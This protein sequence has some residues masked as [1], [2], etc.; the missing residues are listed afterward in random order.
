MPSRSGR[1]RSSKSRLFPWFRSSGKRGESDDARSRALEESRAGAE[2]GTWTRRGTGYDGPAAGGSTGTDTGIGTSRG[3]GS[4]YFPTHSTLVPTTSFSRDFTSI[5]TSATAIPA[6]DTDG[7]PSGFVLSWTGKGSILRGQWPWKNYAEISVLPN[8]FKQSVDVDSS[9]QSSRST[10]SRAKSR[11][12]ELESIYSSELPKQLFG[13]SAAYDESSAVRQRHYED[14][15][16]SM[17]RDYLS[18]GK[19]YSDFAHVPYSG[20]SYRSFKRDEKALKLTGASSLDASPAGSVPG[21][22]VPPRVQPGWE[23]TACSVIVDYRTAA[24]EDAG[25]WQRRKD[26]LTTQ[27][28]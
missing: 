5:R 16:E 1:S 28:R 3:R 19:Q 15:L 23:E 20:H 21:N 26:T 10:T 12:E 17:A 8:P 22:A 25:P 2:T 11:A 14:A 27:R 13:S 4:S 6:G 9:L 24:G 18:Q 7:R